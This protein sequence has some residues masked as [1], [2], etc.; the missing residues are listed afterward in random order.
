MNER[1]EF[2]IAD[3]R[4]DFGVGYAP[5]TRFLHQGPISADDLATFQSHLESRLPWRDVWIVTSVKEDGNGGVTVKGYWAH[6]T[7][8]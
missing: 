5:E 3:E 7:G 2:P 1:T 8:V 6:S 4:V